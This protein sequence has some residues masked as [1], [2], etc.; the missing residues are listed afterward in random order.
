MKKILL[1]LSLIIVCYTQDLISEIPTKADIDNFLNDILP[2]NLSYR[3]MTIRDINNINVNTIY[4]LL[5]KFNYDKSLINAKNK[6]DKS[7]LYLAVLS[8][9]ND[10]VK[11]L[12]AHGADFNEVKPIN[13]EGKIK[14]SVLD[15]AQVMLD[16]ES[17]HMMP[18]HTID[19]IHFKNQ[20]NRI[21]NLKNVIDTLKNAGAKTAAELNK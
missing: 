3:D 17:H 21:Q 8:G 7:A 9:N 4:P 10:L 12:I 14:R 20:S 15:D 11:T 2:L 5:E 6:Y 18:S 1:I 16:A 19:I 13:Y